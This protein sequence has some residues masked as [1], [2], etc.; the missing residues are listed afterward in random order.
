MSAMAHFSVGLGAELDGDFC[1]R[2][3]IRVER[4]GRYHPVYTLIFNDEE[5]ADLNW[6]GPRRVRYTTYPDEV[7]TELR[8][9]TMKRVIRATDA[10]GRI[11]TLATKSNRALARSDMRLQV[12]DGSNFI[13]HRRLVDR[14]GS[15]RFEVRKQYYLNN[16]LVFH[17]DTSDPA[18]PIWIDVE[19]LMR[20]ELPHF[21]RLLSLVTARIGLEQRMSASAG[22]R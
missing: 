12:C 22:R 9:D 8:I 15:C 11:S 6:R 17:C 2:G 19:K 18:A 5:I 4:R 14:W 3:R 1:G 7:R 21:H 10:D 20:W 13:V 16:L